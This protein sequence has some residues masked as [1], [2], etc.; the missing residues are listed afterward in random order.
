M[1]ERPLFD[2]NDVMRRL[3]P[4]MELK[5]QRTPA[6]FAEALPEFSSL[7]RFRG[8]IGADLL[9]KEIKDAATS[10]PHEPTLPVQDSTWALAILG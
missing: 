10:L 9:Y 3:Q 2:I 5:R 4:V 7:P 6:D 8:P 1:P